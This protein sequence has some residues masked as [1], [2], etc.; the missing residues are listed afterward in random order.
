[1][2]QR[3]WK[4]RERYLEKVF[5]RKK[6]GDWAAVKELFDRYQYIAPKTVDKRIELRECKVRKIEDA[7]HSN[8]GDHGNVD[9]A[10]QT[11]LLLEYAKKKAFVARHLQCRDYMV[12]VVRDKLMEK[13]MDANPKNPSYISS[14]AYKWAETET[15]RLMKLLEK[16]LRIGSVLSARQ[17]ETPIRTPFDCVLETECSKMIK[18]M[19]KWLTP[20][21]DRVIRMRF[22]ID[23]PYKTLGEIAGHLSVT[24][25]RVRQIETMALIKLRRSPRSKTLG[26][27]V[28]P[29]PGRSWLTED[30]PENEEQKKACKK[31]DEIILKTCRNDAKVVRCRMIEGLH[32]SEIEKK[33]GISG[34]CARQMVHAHLGTIEKLLV[35]LAAQ[36][37]T[38][39]SVAAALVKGARI[40]EYVR[41]IA[42]AA[43]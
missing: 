15:K 16:E 4:P 26:H 32:W 18:F 29:Q 10:T 12:E 43:R 19:L 1:M 7:L 20:K 23:Y 35:G 30:A 11:K 14:H 39:G 2:Q 22:G 28:A 25:E 42:E 5:N 34:Y 24:P 13:L 36:L 27:F 33:T 41:R 38:S 17:M 9:E 8:N 40:D 21:E 37:G 6:A 3:R 31:V